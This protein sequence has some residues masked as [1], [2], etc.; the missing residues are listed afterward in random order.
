[1]L[2]NS[3]A[4]ALF[5]PIVF[6][7]YWWACRS[8]RSRNWLVLLASWFFYAWWDWRFLGLLILSTGVDFILGLALSRTEKTAYRNGLLGASLFLNLGLLGFFKYFNFFIDGLADLLSAVGMQPH[9]PVLSIV[10]PVGISFYTFQTL[11]YT[12]DIYRRQLAPTRDF[13]A[14]AAFVSF[15]PQLVAGP[16]ERAAN[17]LPQFLQARALQ[18]D[19]AKDGLRQM[20]WGFFKKIA[21]ADSLAPFV[22]GVFS[23]DPATTPGITLFFGAF[24]FAFQ[25]YCDFSGYSDIAIGCARLFGFG[26]SRNFHYPYFSRSLVEFWRRW[27]ISL[28]TWFRDYLYI[29]LGGNRGGRALTAR[30]VVATFVVSGFWHGANWSF[31]G[32]GAAHGLLQLPRTAFGT[33]TL[34]EVPGFRDL[35]AILST[36]L[37]V[38]L[39]WVLFRSSSLIA[40]GRYLWSMAANAFHSPGAA[41][42][43]LGRVEMFLL[44][45]LIAAEW[46]ARAHEHALAG[47]PKSEVARWALYLFITLVTLSQFDLRTEHAFIY[48]QF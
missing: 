8:L 15:F 45:A 21:V 26:L 44:V 40:G 47:M 33:R 41:L 16:I 46:R 23:G 30:N 36:F 14:F 22:E 2:F 6:A 28:S 12:I 11:S 35:P 27:H 48:F 24:F 13:V 7:I 3:F 29:P 39:A 18:L 5:L 38:T 42:L 34:A 17:L 31:V 32:W 37:L 43:H 1:M 19:R 9:L 4:F 25:I 20:L 10:L